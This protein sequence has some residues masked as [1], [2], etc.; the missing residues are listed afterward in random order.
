MFMESYYI[1]FPQ[2]PNLLLA[3]KFQLQDLREQDHFFIAPDHPCILWE[4]IECKDKRIESSHDNPLFLSDLSVMINP[5][6]EGLQDIE[7]KKKAKKMLEEFKSQPFF[8]STML[9]KQQ[10]VKRKWLYEM[11]DGSKRLKGAQYFVGINTMV[12]Y[13]FNNDLINMSNLTEEEKKL[14][15]LE[16][17]SPE[18]L[19]EELLSRIQE[20]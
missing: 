14:I 3:R 10:N 12:K 20:D 4:P 8:K 2:L 11:E 16:L 7:S 5:D 1:F 18:T 15:D 19:T 13:S 17:R 9:C 6:R